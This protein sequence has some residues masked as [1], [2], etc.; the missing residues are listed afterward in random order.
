[1]ELA[2]E[3]VAPEAESLVR[4]HFGRGEKPGPL[5]QVEGVAMPV[6][7]RHPGEMAQRPGAPCFA[8]LQL[9]PADLLGSTRVDPRAERAGHQL[10]AETDAE[11]RPRRGEAALKQRELLPEKRIGEFVIGPD[12]TA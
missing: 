2:G 6:Q 1:M 9:G 7:N 10:R 8:E 12:R 4:A 5:R 3:R 11:R